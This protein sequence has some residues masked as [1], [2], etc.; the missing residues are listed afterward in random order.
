[1]IEGGQDLGREHG[2]AV[3]Q[4]ED[5]GPEAEPLGDS[6]HHRQRG[7]RLQEVGGRRK[8][9]V[10]GRVVGIP[11]ADLERHHHVIARPHRVESHRL[12]PACRRDQRLADGGRPPDGQVVA[13]LDGTAHGS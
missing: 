9:E 2:V 3:R 1:M 12:D 7:Q 13:E 11:R 5:R 8:R 4:H 6:G 10:S